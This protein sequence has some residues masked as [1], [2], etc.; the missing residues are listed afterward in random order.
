MPLHVCS[1]DLCRR[2][3][4]APQA[5]SNNLVDHHLILDLVPP[6]AHAYFA[7]ALPA[8]LSYSQAAILATLGLQQHEIG[9]VGALLARVSGALVI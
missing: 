4:Y 5:Y 1:S 2:P 3:R 8:P 6:L 7:G 9:K